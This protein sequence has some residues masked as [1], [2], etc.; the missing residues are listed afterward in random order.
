MSSVAFE[1]QLLQLDGV[2][3]EEGEA[4]LRRKE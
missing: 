4:E 1:C 2:R 3:Q